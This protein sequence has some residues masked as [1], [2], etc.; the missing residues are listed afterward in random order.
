[1]NDKRLHVNWLNIPVVYVLDHASS[2]LVSAAE[3]WIWN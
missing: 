1:L 3:L 2:F